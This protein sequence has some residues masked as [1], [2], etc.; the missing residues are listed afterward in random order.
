MGANLDG[1]LRSRLE[2]SELAFR[3]V[4][5]SGC[6]LETLLQFLSDPS[7]NL[8]KARNLPRLWEWFISEPRN[9]VNSMRL[10]NWLRRHLS[11]GM[12]SGRELHDLIEMALHSSHDTSGIQQDRDL[13]R[14][15]L[16]GLSGSGVDQISDLGGDILNQLLLLVSFNHSSQNSEWQTLCF[17]IFEVCK[18]AQ[19]RHMT[20]G[21]SSLLTSYLESASPDRET[22]LCEQQ[23]SKILDCLLSCSKVEA[24]RA[25]ASAS[26]ALLMRSRSSHST[27][28]LSRQ[29][30]GQWW[31]L[32][33]HHKIFELIKY[34]P[35]WLRIER[36]LAQ[37]NTDVLCMYMKYISDDEKCIFLLRHWFMQ[38]LEDGDKLSHRNVSCA[39]K[40][41]NERL[42]SRKG[43]TCPFIFLF[44]YLRPAVAADR[45]ALLRLFSLLNK[46]DL[47]ESSLNLYSHFLQTNAPIE[48]S[49]LAKDIIDYTSPTP[50]MACTLYKITPFLPLESCPSV[51]ETMIL[52]TDDGLGVP[53]GFR[54]LR[55]KSLGVSNVYPRTVD[56]IL[57]AQIELL[58][59]M[60]MAY[61]QASHLYPRVAFRQ[62]Y[63][64]Y[65]L[66]VRRHGRTSLSVA[67]SRAFTLAGLIKPLQKARWVGT[68]QLTFVLRIIKEIEGD[69]VASKMDELLYIWRKHLIE[70]KADKAWDLHL[71]QRLG[72]LPPDE[73]DPATSLETMIEAMR[74]EEQRE[75]KLALHGTGKPRGKLPGESN[76]NQMVR[77]RTARDITFALAAQRAALKKHNIR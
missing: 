24:S 10:H 27:W 75:A 45:I 51:A 25:I 29:N 19:L 18:P 69:E 8:Q 15:I 72:F 30:A 42:V 59:R 76:G 40:L 77:E 6:D 46:L 73:R 65:R 11:L 43:H 60:A 50:Q 36:A 37:D 35:E 70:E 33:L 5:R 17:K 39:I 2:F 71:K 64:C 26:Q 1:Q 52:N 23:V 48:F 67:I 62:V 7:L 38:Y 66:L 54:V 49:A 61:A 21:I 22:R 68:T 20:M 47:P 4:L 3:R 41:F 63:Q 44:K 58:N 9:K 57:C 14:T 53:F 56:E 12:Q 74:C 28:H 55:R 31:S 16:D 32:L 34:R 13:H